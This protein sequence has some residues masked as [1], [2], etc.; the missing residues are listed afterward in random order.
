MTSK[1]FLKSLIPPILMPTVIKGYS[2]WHNFKR[3]PRRLYYDL[4]KEIKN[5]PEIEKLFPAENV[6]KHYVYEP[7]RQTLDYPDLFATQ[8][9]YYRMYKFFQENYPELFDNNTKVIDVG[10][11]SGILFKA[12][13]R[14]GLSVNLNPEVVEF[15]KRQGIEAK[16]GNI[17][18]LPFEDNSFDYTFSF[19]CIEHVKNPVKALDELGRITRK[20]VFISIPYVLQTRIY[21]VKYWQELKKKPIEC[22]GWGESEPREVDCHV[23]EF[24]TEDFIKLLSHTNLKYCDNFPIN[25]FS[26]L[27]SERENKGSYFN[28]FILEPK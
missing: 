1:E 18:E 19:Q 26:P 25:Y 8:L 10:D 9:R 4:E 22:G 24:S 2:A 28:F 11:T 16:L 27:G 13:G 21:D 23:F 7:V 12:M 5:N 14:N 17:E 15:I 3:D 20:K 6:K